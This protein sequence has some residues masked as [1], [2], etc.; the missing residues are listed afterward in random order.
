MKRK[1]QIRRPAF[2]CALLCLLIALSGCQSMEDQN[3]TVPA[4]EKSETIT[5]KFFGNKNEALT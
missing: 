4:A 2:L 3:Y 1:D 5:L